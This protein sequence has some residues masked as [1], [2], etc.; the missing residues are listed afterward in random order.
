M[1]WVAQCGY[2]KDTDRNGALKENSHLKENARIDKE[3]L[4]IYAEE[5]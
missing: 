1:L 5:Y 4:S 2:N 3:S